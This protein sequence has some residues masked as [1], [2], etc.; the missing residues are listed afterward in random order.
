MLFLLSKTYYF[1]KPMELD[2]TAVNI[3][4]GFDRDQQKAILSAI[5]V[6][7]TSKWIVTIVKV[8]YENAKRRVIV[9]N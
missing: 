2:S 9:N 8:M 1:A 6:F 7:E 3:E 5:T 4:N